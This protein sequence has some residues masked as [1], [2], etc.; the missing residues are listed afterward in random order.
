[1]RCKL[2]QKQT[3]FKDTAMLTRHA[4]WLRRT[5]HLLYQHDDHVIAWRRYMAKQNDDP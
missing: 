5:E 4:S 1:M 2:P 3:R